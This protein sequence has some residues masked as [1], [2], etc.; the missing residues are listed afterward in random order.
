MIK[1]TQRVASLRKLPRIDR[2]ARGSLKVS[3]WLACAQPDQREA[4]MSAAVKRHTERN[5]TFSPHY[6]RKLS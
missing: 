4:F 5:L 1:P 2:M 3:W 6:G